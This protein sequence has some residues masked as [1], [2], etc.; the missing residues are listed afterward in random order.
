MKSMTKIL[1]LGAVAVVAVAISV[2]PSEARTKRAPKAC[3]PGAICTMAKTGVVHHCAGDRKLVPVLLPA[4]QGSG[5][6]P[7]C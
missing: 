3:M 1:L 5:C 2:A 6:P 7:H 4:C